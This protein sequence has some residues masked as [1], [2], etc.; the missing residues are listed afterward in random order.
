MKWLR[1]DQGYVTLVN[2]KKHEDGT[3]EE[4]REKLETMLGNIT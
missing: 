2:I 1:Q 4:V 3:F